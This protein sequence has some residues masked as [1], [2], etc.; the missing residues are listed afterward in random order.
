MPKMHAIERRPTVVAPAETPGL[1]GLLTLA[2]AVVV[3]AGLYLGRTVLIPIT[4]A[5][6]LSFLL[7]PIVNLLRRIHFGRVLSV[8]VA[9]MLALGVILALGGLIGT[10]IAELAQEVPRYATTI[11]DKV[12]TVQGFAASEMNLVMRRLEHPPSRRRPETQPPSAEPKPMQVEVHQPDPTPIATRRTHH[13]PDRRPAVDHRHRADRHHLRAAAARG[14]AR[15]PDPPV[16]LV[17]PAPHHR[18]DER[19]RPPPV[20]LLPHPARHQRR[21]WRHHRHRPVPHRRAVP[22]AVGHRR[23]AAALRA[24]YRRPAGRHP[25]P[26]PGRRRQPRLVHGA[27]DRRPLRRHRGDHGP[28]RRAPAVRPQHR[29]V[30]VLRRGLRHVLDLAVGPDRPDPVHAR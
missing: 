8:L 28:G 22:A 26:G 18:G 3:V 21:L 27:V 25:A 1:S 29:P 20:P 17:R 9:V 6:L 13:H 11:R 7:A 23:P 4:L 16:R 10:Q 24:L 5:V 15:P 12:D 30:P 2:V 19:R 14:P